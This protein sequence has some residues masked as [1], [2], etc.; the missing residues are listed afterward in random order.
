[1]FGFT[2]EQIT[3]FCLPCG[4]GILLLFALFKPIY[5]AGAEGRRRLMC[6]RSTANPS[7]M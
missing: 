4:I 3:S 6:A 1:M 5:F 7:M 2:E